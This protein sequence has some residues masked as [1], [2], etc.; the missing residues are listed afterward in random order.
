VKRVASTGIFVMLL[1]IGSHALAQQPSPDE[2]TVDAEAGQV[3][4]PGEGW[5]GTDDFWALYLNEPEKLPGTS[6]FS[7]LTE[8]GYPDTIPVPE[9]TEWI[10]LVSGILFLATVGCKHVR[11]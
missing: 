1:V 2:L 11:M 4:V 5:L 6:D 7:Q 3:Y 10:L 9:P 8:L